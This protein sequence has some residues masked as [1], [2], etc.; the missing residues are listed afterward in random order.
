MS[1]QTPYKKFAEQFTS[2][3]NSK[4]FAN[5]KV[6]IFQLQTGGGKSYFQDKEMPIVLKKAFPELKFIFRLSPTNEVARDGT[7]KKVKE[8]SGEYIFAYADDP[9]E[10][11]TSWD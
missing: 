6:K 1:I 9:I 11:F 3:V 5:N 2:T 10:T 4:D 8:L 7:F